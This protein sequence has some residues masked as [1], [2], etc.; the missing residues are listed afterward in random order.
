MRGAVE[1]AGCGI[2]PETPVVDPLQMKRRLDKR[3]VK[4]S[5]QRT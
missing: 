2:E 1:D 4:Y 3:L 5:W